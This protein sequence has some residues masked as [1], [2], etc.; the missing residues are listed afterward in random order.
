METGRRGF[1][2]VVAAGLAVG[3]T[4]ISNLSS[5][6]PAEAAA[7]RAGCDDPCA[8]VY[9]V[10]EGHSCGQYEDCPV[11]TGQRCIGIYYYY[12]VNVRG[13]WCSQRF[14]DEGSCRR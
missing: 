4:A 1:L 11:G 6:T 2:K 13:Y 8:A 10:Y 9:E 3:F 12:S 14:D 5:K 7:C